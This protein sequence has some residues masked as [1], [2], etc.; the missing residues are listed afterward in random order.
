M[1]GFQPIG[2]SGPSITSPN[3][4]G[5]IIRKDYCLTLQPAGWFELYKTP[6][7][8]ERT[9]QEFE[10]LTLKR[11]EML[12]VLH[13]EEGLERMDR[14]ELIN[15]ITAASKGEKTRYSKGVFEW[16]SQTEMNSL[17]FK[18]ETQLR[19]AYRIQLRDIQQ[20]STSSNRFVQLNEK[21]N[22]ITSYNKELPQMRA[23]KT[24]ELYEKAFI[25]DSISHW[26]CRLAFCG[27]QK[28]RD[29]FVRHEETLFKGRVM[30]L[31]A[32]DQQLLLQ[33]HCS[34]EP[35]DIQPQWVDSLAQ[36]MSHFNVKLRGIPSQE[37]IKNEIIY[38]VPWNAVP[39]LVRD[40]RVY[41]TQG[42]ALITH[43]QALSLLFEAFRHE[44]RESL[45]QCVKARP[46]I[47]AKEKDR[48]SAFLNK[49][50]MQ[51]ASI[52]E[53]PRE[54]KSEGGLI[55]IEDIA[56]HAN[57]H[58]PLCMGQI[59]RFLRSE[60]HLKYA[61]RFQ[62][63]TFLKDA[64]LTLESS[65]KFFSEFMTLKTTPAKFSK[66]EY[67]YSVRYNYGREGKKTNYKGCNCSTLITGAQPKA[68]ECHGCPFKSLP[69]NRL[70][71]LLRETKPYPVPTSSDTKSALLHKT[72]QPKDEHIRNILKSLC[73]FFIFYFLK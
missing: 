23:K 42:I 45:R 13:Q 8:G 34:L 53:K 16:V 7:K 67:G 4:A 11:I 71:Q 3:T 12:A 17:L 6:A 72:I 9:V 51:S 38:T 48:I 65:L 50:V 37:V 33:T 52:L 56:P 27:E 28:W 64:G 29:W 32:A 59:D 66:S 61:G 20:H 19:E 68:G 15:E 5:I 49:A 54:N 2:S 47:D 31:S 69:E 30:A 24:N 22:N 57:M 1:S 14:S 73:H 43:S 40:R 26:A 55:D 41:V 62:Y 35:C 46:D 18:E 10:E 44:L 60:R 63:M 58:M 36:M 21:G 70:K 39:Y 25:N